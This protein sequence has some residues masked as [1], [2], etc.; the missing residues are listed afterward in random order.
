MYFGTLTIYE[1]RKVGKYS[2]QEISIRDQ[3]SS[4]RFRHKQKYSPL[5]IFLLSTLIL[6][7]QWITVETSVLILS[8]FAFLYLRMK[9]LNAIFSEDPKCCPF[10]SFRNQN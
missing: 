1:T 5:S 10:V 3:E 8:H 7:L 9:I 2:I 4:L 6:S